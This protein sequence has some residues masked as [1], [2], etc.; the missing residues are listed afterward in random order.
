MYLT[1]LLVSGSGSNCHEVDTH[2]AQRALFPHH[3]KVYHTLTHF[4][5]ECAFPIVEN[6]ETKCETSSEAHIGQE[7]KKSPIS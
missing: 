2:P 4:R 1:S 6:R 7:W 3:I 5:A